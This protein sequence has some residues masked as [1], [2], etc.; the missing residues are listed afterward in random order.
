MNRIIVAFACLL[1]AASASFLNVGNQQPPQ[2]LA[3]TTALVE[4]YAGD[5]ISMESHPLANHPLKVYINT[6][7]DN[8]AQQMNTDSQGFLRIQVDIGAKIFVTSVA[9]N[10]FHE[11][12]TSIVTVPPQGLNGLFGRIVLQVPSNLIYDLFKLLIGRPSPSNMC[13]VVVTITQYNKTYTDDPQGFPG[14]VATIDPAGDA[15]G[16]ARPYYFNTMLNNKTNPLPNNLTATSFDGG[17]VFPAIPV[18]PGSDIIIS[19]QY[20]DVPFTTST[21]R[22]LRPGQFINAA[23]NQ[24]PKATRPLTD[25]I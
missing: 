1:V 14:V 2:R 25:D 12:T 8:A 24:G 4:V 6:F 17:V 20:K 19:G 23:P 7:D 11:T 15:V 10:D 3:A 22:C 18:G 13:Q 9:A 5:F 21:I 16:P